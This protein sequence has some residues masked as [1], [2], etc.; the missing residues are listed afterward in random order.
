MIAQCFLRAQHE[1][2]FRHAVGLSRRGRDDRGA[3]HQLRG[4]PGERAD[5][6]IVAY[7]VLHEAAVVIARGR[8]SLV[9]DR[10]LRHDFVQIPR[11]QDGNHPRPPSAITENAGVP[12]GGHQGMADA[13]RLQ[14]V[15][16]AVDHVALGDADYLPLTHNLNS[17]STETGKGNQ[18]PTIRS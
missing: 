11:I 10:N 4:V 12:T 2:G 18:Q 16:A 15:D 13:H 7:P 9:G 17:T 14:D 8:D 3:A 5:D 1:S 6:V